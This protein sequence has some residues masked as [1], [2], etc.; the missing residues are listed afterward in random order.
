MVDG[1]VGGAV[2]VLE[3]WALKLWRDVSCLT[4]FEALDHFEGSA[5]S[6]ACLN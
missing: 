2:D 4:R 5:G 6:M 3:C 1:N